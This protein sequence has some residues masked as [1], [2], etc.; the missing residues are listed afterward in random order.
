MIKVIIDAS[1]LFEYSSISHSITILPQHLLLHM[2]I[3]EA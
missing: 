1:D 2:S 3:A